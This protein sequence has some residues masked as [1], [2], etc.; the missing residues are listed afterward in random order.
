MASIRHVCIGLCLLSLLYSVTAATVV[1]NEPQKEVLEGFNVTISCVVE[2]IFNPSSMTFHW[3]VPG[4]IGRTVQ[5]SDGIP[6][7]QYLVTSDLPEP[8]GDIGTVT[9]TSTLTVFGANDTTDGTYICQLFDNDNTVVATSETELSVIT[10]DKTTDSACWVEPSKIALEG[11]K[12]TFRCA[13][14][15]QGDLSELDLAVGSTRLDGVKTVVSGTT[16]VSQTISVPLDLDQKDVSCVDGISGDVLCSSSVSLM[17]HPR[18]TV[19]PDGEIVYDSDARFNCTATDGR[20]RFYLPMVFDAGIN[21][22]CEVTNAV[23]TGRNDPYTIEGREPRS[24]AST[25]GP[26]L[27]AVIFL[28]I[29]IV[30]IIFFIWRRGQKRMV[31][32]I[33]TRRKMIAKDNR[34]TSELPTLQGSDYT[35]HGSFV[36]VSPM[37]LE[38]MGYGPDITSNKSNK[39]EPND[40]DSGVGDD[41]IRPIP[42][43]GSVSSSVGK[44]NYGYEQDTQS[45]SDMNF[46]SAD[47]PVD[48]YEQKRCQ[49]ELQYC[50]KVPSISHDKYL[51]HAISTGGDMIALKS[52]SYEVNPNFNSY[53]KS[54]IFDVV[55]IPTSDNEN[56]DDSDTEIRTIASDSGGSDDES[57]G[58]PS[59]SGH[60]ESTTL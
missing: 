58:K 21:L 6:D 37:D 17:F 16:F 35:G 31:R 1:N 45:Q 36:A 55:T 59:A 11:S 2:D 54:Q 5:A 42:R 19:V 38:A 57:V 13:T 24:V 46:E 29:I 20:W 40:R 41:G 9:G 26:I 12:V 25:V 28:I 18:V 10:F 51:E 56:G 32:S 34:N 8:R 48:P 44:V 39:V 3:T 27:L 23:G 33:S 49:Q 50:F 53:R 52:Y 30:L 60:I 15:N 47:A 14:R 43:R 7:G 4:I 22:T